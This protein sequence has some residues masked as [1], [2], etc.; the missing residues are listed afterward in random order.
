VR[1]SCRW[2]DPEEE[3][4]DEEEDV[5]TSAS[6]QMRGLS[7]FGGAA[8]EDEGAGGELAEEGGDEPYRMSEVRNI[9]K[10]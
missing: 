5:A 6:D 2:W 7:G 4:T 8:T 9:D 1:R 3:E 10:L